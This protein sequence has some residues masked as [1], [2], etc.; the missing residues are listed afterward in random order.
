VQLFLTRAQHSRAGFAFTDEN[1]PHIVRICQ[2]VDGL[3]LGIELAAARL[4]EYTCQQIVALLQKSPGI[5]TTQVQDIPARHRSIQAALDPSWEG[6]SVAERQLF[7]H[8][9]QFEG[10]FSLEEASQVAGATRAKLLELVGKYF[11]TSRAPGRYAI[12]PLLRGYAQEKTR[13]LSGLELD[14]DQEADTSLETETA[15]DPLTDLPGY[16]LFID[17][18]D[19]LLARAIRRQQMAAVVL[20]SLEGLEQLRQGD[21]QHSFNSAL[22]ALSQRFQGCLRKSDTLAR[23]G[24]DEFALLLEEITS[25]QDCMR[26]AERIALSVESFKLGGQE[27]HLQVYMGGSIYPWDSDQPQALLQRARIALDKARE[28]GVICQLFSRRVNGR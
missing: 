17:R 8:L 5:L 13:P 25:V 22:L 19:H 28:T 3:P 18:L 11:L 4:R 14:A 20:V 27:I 24:E 2:L 12:H 1:Q 23:V 10:E 26:V 7:V 16:N 15:H 21:W 9:A 6:L